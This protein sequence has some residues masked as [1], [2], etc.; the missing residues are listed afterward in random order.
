MLFFSYVCIIISSRWIPSRD[1]DQIETEI[2][3]R[4]VTVFF[5]RTETDNRN[6]VRANG[7]KRYS[8]R[9]YFSVRFQSRFWFG[10]FNFFDTLVESIV[11]RRDYSGILKQSYRM[12]VKCYFL[13]FFLDYGNLR[14]INMLFC[15]NLSTSCKQL[16][17]CELLTLM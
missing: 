17:R 11:L 8:D 3:N 9:K 2:D 5:C 15:R 12:S 10:F 4:I 16:K 6:I 13:I 1:S 7:S 14:K